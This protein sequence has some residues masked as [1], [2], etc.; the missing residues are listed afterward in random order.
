MESRRRIPVIAV[1]QE[2]PLVAFDGTGKRHLLGRAVVL[3]N[4]GGIAAYFDDTAGDSFVT[5]VISAIMHGAVN[6]L[7][8]TPT[9]PNQ[10]PEEREE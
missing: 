10:E 7:T 2:V 4:E 8:I 5:K 9:I 6:A 1:D 3:K